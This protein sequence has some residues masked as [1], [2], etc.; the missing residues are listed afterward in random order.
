MNTVKNHV[1]QYGIIL[2]FNQDM[3]KYSNTINLLF[4]IIILILVQ[5]CSSRLVV[6]KQPDKD[7]L[8]PLNSDGVRKLKGYPIMLLKPRAVV[9]PSR[10]QQ[11]TSSEEKTFE[12]NFAVDL[13]YD[14]PDDNHRYYINV[15][16]A[17]LSK[18]EM[19]LKFG[20]M[21]NLKSAGV[22]TTSQSTE[23]IKTFGGFAVAI[24]GGFPTSI[25][26][27]GDSGKQE[28]IVD[29]IRNNVV[30]LDCASLT[31]AKDGISSSDCA[32]SKIDLQ[33]RMTFY[34]NKPDQFKK[35][36]Y[37]RNENEK[38][39]FKIIAKQLS[40]EVL[41][42][43]SKQPAVKLCD[44]D[45]VKIGYCDNY[46]K[47]QD[48]ISGGKISDISSQNS[49]LFTKIKAFDFNTFLSSLN[50]NVR[51]DTSFITATKE[52]CNAVAGNIS[53]PNKCWQSYIKTFDKNALGIK[54]KAEAIQNMYIIINLKSNQIIWRTILFLESKIQDLKL[55]RAQLLADCSNYEIGQ[56]NQQ[57]TAAEEQDDVSV[58]GDLQCPDHKI[59]K[60]DESSKNT[61]IKKIDKE[62]AS[63]D[64]K[65]VKILNLEVEYLR[66]LQY[67]QF[68]AKVPKEKLVAPGGNAVNSKVDTKAIEEIEKK[69]ES[70]KNLR[71]TRR[72]ALKP[73]DPKKPG[74]P[75]YSTK[76]EVKVRY[77]QKTNDAKA[78]DKYIKKFNGKN[79]PYL[80]FIEVDDCT[81]I[82]CEPIASLK[83]N[84]N[85]NG[86]SQ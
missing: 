1:L 37:L 73:P 17:Y 30:N 24:A 38:I 42:E 35:E 25:T 12:V 39:I 19:E 41:I 15:D 53:D 13:V 84:Q 56:C 52:L 29:V 27:I 48:S 10:D 36:F 57:R 43:L 72:D 65:I 77:I 21:G 70:F 28:D 6:Q 60:C 75:K 78:L 69:I 50:N 18:N 44:I 63:N 83:S 67:K 45:N 8:G 58:A 85:S 20:P 47:I 68:L 22:T 74:V 80:I 62:I 54:L 16:P 46:T 26:G 23:L 81:N 40:Q 64:N 34:K 31:V 76:K 9:T 59:G 66:D 71:K 32:V 33:N 5:S 82:D 11:I 3:K 7:Q 14:L 86:G 4:L 51:S 79:D 49:V 2:K 55:A 61:K